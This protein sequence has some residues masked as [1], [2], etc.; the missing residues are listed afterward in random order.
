MGF[1]SVRQD[2]CH[3][4]PKI[5][6][7][8]IHKNATRT[9]K[10]RAIEKRVAK[11]WHG[12]VDGRSSGRKMTGVSYVIIGLFLRP[13]CCSPCTFN[14]PH[15]KTA[16][17][18]ALISKRSRQF[19]P[20]PS[21]EAANEGRACLNDRFDKSLYHSPTTMVNMLR[22]ITASIAVLVSF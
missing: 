14:C 15:A 7:E 18:T 10:M 20:C 5:R 8:L 16:P 1:G 22:V 13:V 17:P 6:R 12:G 3:D 9:R 2:H 21:H 4:L 11:S 19:Y